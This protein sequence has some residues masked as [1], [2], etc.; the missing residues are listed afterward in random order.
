M[1]NP[2]GEFD[3][4]KK[5]RGLQFLTEI[6]KLGWLFPPPKYHYLTA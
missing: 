2:A 5:E 6:K 3:W 4:V 1:K